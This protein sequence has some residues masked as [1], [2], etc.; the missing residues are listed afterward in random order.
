MNMDEVIDNI[1]SQFSSLEELNNKIN[2]KWEKLDNFI[3]QHTQEEGRYFSYANKKKIQYNWQTTRAVQQI[4][5]KNLDQKE[6]FVELLIKAE[7]D[8]GSRLSSLIFLELVKNIS[9]WENQ[10]KFLSEYYFSKWINDSENSNSLNSFVVLNDGL[11]EKFYNLDHKLSKDIKENISNP[12]P[13]IAYWS[14][15]WVWEQEWYDTFFLNEFEKNINHEDWRIRVISIQYLNVW[16]KIYKNKK[17]KNLNIHWNDYLLKMINRKY[18]S[19][20]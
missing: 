13:K 2:V 15:W 20:I 17:Y 11:P 9:G 4:I 18:E 16:G 1:Y 19:K 7:D 5:S 3:E 10:I 8:Y 12:N 14:M 6:L